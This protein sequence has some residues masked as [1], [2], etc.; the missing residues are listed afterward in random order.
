MTPPERF[1]YFANDLI[2][3]QCVIVR[4]LDPF[5]FKRFGVIRILNDLIALKVAGDFSTRRRNADYFLACRKGKYTLEEA[6]MV[7]EFLEKDLNSAYESSRLSDK[8]DV[9]AINQLLIELNLE[10]LSLE[11]TL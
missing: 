5:F 4:L 10:A 8:P 3:S 6:M 1:L 11:K 2:F 9:A 7:L